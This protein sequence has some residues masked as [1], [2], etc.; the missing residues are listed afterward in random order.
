MCG[1]AGRMSFHI[2]PLISPGKEHPGCDLTASASVE[3]QFLQDTGG[4]VLALGQGMA[5][6]P[7]DRLWAVLLFPFLE[8]DVNKAYDMDHPA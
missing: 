1:R 5:A 8:F 6:V 7:K 4:C 3:D 2:F